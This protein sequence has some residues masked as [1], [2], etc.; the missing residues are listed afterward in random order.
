MSSIKPVNVAIFAG[1][2]G[3]RLGKPCKPLTL[4]NGK[5]LLLHCIDKIEEDCVGRLAICSNNNPLLQGHPLLTTK[6]YECIEDQCPGFGPLSALAGAMAWC[7][8]THN[9][10]L[11]L[12]CPADTPF[13][14]DNLLST[15][16]DTWH[17]NQS[18]A[19]VC[20]SFGRIHPTVGLWSADKLEL[21][22]Q[23]FLKKTNQKK[24]LQRWLDQCRTTI[25]DFTNDGND[26][27]FNINTPG[28]LAHANK[29]K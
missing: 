21:R 5:P 10:A 27:F 4:L 6:G 1:G 18:E 25:L 16:L 17:A 14:P 20:S 23:H 24:S 19:L 15:L 29:L 13:L 26:P 22:L 3:K 9:G 11:L 8:R 28:E 2:E 12:T 7:N